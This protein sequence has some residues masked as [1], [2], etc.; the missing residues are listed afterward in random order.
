MISESGASDHGTMLHY[1][2]AQAPGEG[3]RVLLASRFDSSN[4]LP[5]LAVGVLK[6][7]EM[8]RL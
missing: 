2:A 4:P 1:I 7:V 6:Q 5:K 3:F 8:L